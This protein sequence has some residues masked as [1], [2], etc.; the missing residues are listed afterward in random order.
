M[1]LYHTVPV[2]LTSE[3]LQLTKVAV[4][5]KGLPSGDSE[6]N[7]DIS[8]GARVSLPFF[9]SIAHHKNFNE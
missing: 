3:L 1:H 2:L 6:A 7:E 8:N 9:L 5:F 4:L